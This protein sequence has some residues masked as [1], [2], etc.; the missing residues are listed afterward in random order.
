M[1]CEGVG[2]ACASA[3]C[4]PALVTCE[5]SEGAQICL[6]ATTP[7][8][9]NGDPHRGRPSSTPSIPTVNKGTNVAMLGRLYSGRLGVASV[10][11]ALD[12]LARSRHG[13]LAGGRS[14]R[15]RGLQFTKEVLDDQLNSLL[16]KYCII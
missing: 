16:D 4:C 10:E 12:S 15:D 2:E 3:M 13:Q 5:L 14:R 9:V 6:S 11:K 7:A 1:R 8:L